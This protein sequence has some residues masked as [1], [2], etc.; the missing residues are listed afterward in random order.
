MQ[1][2]NEQK[3]IWAWAM[4][5]WAN[6][7]YNMVITSTIFPAYFV[8]ITQVIKI[9]TK[10]S[11]FF[12]HKY[13]NTVLSTYVFGSFLPYYC[14]LLLPILTSIADYKGQKKLYLQMFTWLG[15]LACACLYF[16]YEDA[17]FQMQNFEFG[18]I[19]FG[20][21]SVG[22]CGG[23]VF[24]NS[25]LPQIATVD[26]QD[27]VSAKGFIYGFAGSIVVQVLC[28]VPVIFPIFS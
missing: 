15:S 10:Q 21:A 3:T 8:S 19:C 25:Y 27:A 2:K 24:Y 7:A 18:M 5:D 26:Q 16:M 9:Q 1:E 23:F 11:L 6:Q 13:V 28:L 4:F 14:S 20:L 22:Y 17:H 12:G